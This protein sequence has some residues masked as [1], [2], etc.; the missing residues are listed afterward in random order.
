[1]K[2]KN[3]WEILKCGRQM[4]GENVEELGICPAAQ[5]SK[6]DGTNR[7][8]RSGR[9][10]WFVA[11]TMCA[12]KVSGTFATKLMSCIHCEVFKYINEQEGRNFVLTIWEDRNE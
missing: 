4:G 10:C 3:C 12:G 11:G 1:M 9:F 2:R 8:E 7:G 6:H 5:P